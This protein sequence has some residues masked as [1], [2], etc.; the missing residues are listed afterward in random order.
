MLRA[1]ARLSA[2][3]MMQQLHQVLVGRRAGRLD[4]EDVARAH[5]LLD[6][7]VDLAVGEA[8]DLGLAEADRTGAWRFPAPAPDSRCR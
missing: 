4:H 8:A 1:E 6:L 5:V 2:S 3:T 7:D